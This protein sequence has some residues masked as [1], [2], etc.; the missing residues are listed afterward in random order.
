MKPLITADWNPEDGTRAKED[1]I[2]LNIYF[3]KTKNISSYS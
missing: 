3:A 1:P 2:Y